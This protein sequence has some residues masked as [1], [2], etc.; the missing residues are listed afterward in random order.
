MLNTVAS[1][2]ENP[3]YNGRQVWNRRV[4]TG[5]PSG[6]WA[7]STERSHPALVSDA[8]FVAAQAIR[9]TRPTSNGSIRVYLLAGLLLC[10]LSDRRM[11]SHWA[12]GRPGYRCRHGYNSTRPRPRDA[13]K[14]LYL[15]EDHLLATLGQRLAPDINHAA[16][17]QRIAS[18][19]RSTGLAVVCDRAACTVINI[20]QQNRSA[21][22]G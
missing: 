21:C 10:G 8:D 11:D 19:L 5:D 3:R 4:T 14:S 22:E 2:L 20:A 13:P 7:I 16:E 18:H 9:A 17:P 15:R 6:S 12:N 1:I